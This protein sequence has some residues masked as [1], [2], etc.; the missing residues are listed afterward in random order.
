M[1]LCSAIEVELNCNCATSW[2][3]SGIT[4]RLAIN[5]VAKKLNTEKYENFKRRVKH[6]GL[7]KN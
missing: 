5:M 1:L 3:S 4:C 6:L 7:K 2:G